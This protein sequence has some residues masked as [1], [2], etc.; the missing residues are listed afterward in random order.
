MNT[1]A[2]DPAIMFEDL[3]IGD[4]F[5]HGSTCHK[6]LAIDADARCVNLSTTEHSAKYTTARFS[7]IIAMMRNG[8]SYE[9]CLFPICL[10]LTQQTPL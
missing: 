9:P 10:D 1:L 7:K 4:I 2:T 5:R 3:H 6:I 8:F